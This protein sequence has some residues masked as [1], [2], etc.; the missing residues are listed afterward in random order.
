MGYSIESA[1][2]LSVKDKMFKLVVGRSA[3]KNRIQYTMINLALSVTAMAEEA[4]DLIKSKRGSFACISNDSTKLAVLY[5][6]YVQIVH[7]DNPEQKVEFEHDR[8]VTCAAF[9][10]NGTMLATGD[11]R[12]QINLRFFESSLTKP[13]TASTKLHWHAHSLNTLIFSADGFYLYS[14]GAESVLVRWQISSSNKTFLPRL[15]SPIVQLS[16]H[17]DGQVLAAS[18]QE[19][20]IKLLSTANW[21]LETDVI[22]LKYATAVGEWNHPTLMGRQGALVRDPKRNCVVMQ[23]LP[24]RLQFWRVDTNQHVLEVEVAPSPKINRSESGMVQASWVRHVAFSPDG[25]WMATV[26]SREGEAP[27]LKLWQFNS[28]RSHFD[29]ITRVDEAHLSQVTHLEFAPSILPGGHAPLLASSSTDG[30]FR[31]WQL[32]M[33]KQ[34]RSANANSKTSSSEY[35]PSWFCRAVGSWH[36]LPAQDLTFSNDG[37]ILAVAF[38]HLITL[39]EPTTMAC[40]G[41]LSHPAPTSPLQMVQFGGVRSGDQYNEASLYLMAATQHSLYM[42]NVLEGQ[43]KWKK[44]RAR[45]NILAVEPEYGHFVLGLK[46]ENDSENDYLVIVDPLKDSPSF[47]HTLT[48]GLTGLSSLAVTRGR[49]WAS[50]KSKHQLIIMN[51]Q[52]EFESLDDVFEVHVAEAE[53]QR[54]PSKGLLSSIFGTPNAKPNH[55]SRDEPKVSVRVA[56]SSFKLFDAPSHA[57]PPVS[58]LFKPFMDTLLM[59]RK[60]KEEREEGD[61]RET[62]ESVV[63]ATKPWLGGPKSYL[64]QPLVTD[65][66]FLDDYLLQKATTVQ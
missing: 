64:K 39:W 37:S 25:N 28:E 10:P 43:L 22:G 65:L 36:D 26:D 29:L 5:K 59:P 57:L 48:R 33:V 58:R 2:V 13:P 35:L 55:Q 66:S 53:L 54:E 60:K 8:S 19:N 62:D 61:E 46:R 24:G 6:Q 15:G 9:H 51:S 45:A 52:F 7:L 14:G 38:G 31:M 40:H 21:E 49:T 63:E 32:K 23:G 1:S 47:T 17:E 12:G 20:R 41:T 30:T 3:E 16:I 34:Y 56:T 4:I 27:C 50:N 18:L 42:W 11:S 44:T